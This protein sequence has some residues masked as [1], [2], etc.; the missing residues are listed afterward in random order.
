MLELKVIKMS[1]ITVKEFDE[2]MLTVVKRQIEL[3]SDY[4]PEEIVKIVL[5]N[6]RDKNYKGITRRCI[7]FFQ[8]INV[9]SVLKSLTGYDFEKAIDVYAKRINM[10]LNQK[11]I[12]NK[13]DERLDVNYI[14]NANVLDVE[15]VKQMLKGYS[16]DEMIA[17]LEQAYKF[18][19]SFSKLIDQGH[20]YLLR[21]KTSII[22]N[23]INSKVRNFITYIENYDL[24]QNNIYLDH[25]NASKKN[26]DDFLKSDL[27]YEQ[28]VKF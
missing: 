11:Q 20:Y 9:E 22:G 25:I 3:K 21:N 4:T 19:D 14:I 2:V 17:I 16:K 18:N 27:P 23:D 28:K 13:E 15:Q 8:S 7:P 24:Y 10:L 26:L 1:N 5:K 6:A 12:I